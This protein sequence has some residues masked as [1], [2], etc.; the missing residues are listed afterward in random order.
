M[1]WTVSD[2]QGDPAEAAIAHRLCS[3]LHEAIAASGAT[4]AVVEALLH[5]VSDMLLDRPHD[6]FEAIP[7]VTPGT[8]HLVISF[9]ILN[10]LRCYLAAS[11]S[12]CV[13][14]ARTTHIKRLLH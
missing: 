14:V 12:Y 10:S 8:G 7:T 3:E 11:T 9:G 4:Q 2:A 6:V 5:D 1:N 13:G